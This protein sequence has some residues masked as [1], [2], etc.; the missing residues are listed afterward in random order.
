MSTDTPEPVRKPRRSRRLT[1]LRVLFGA[2]ALGL[3]ILLAAW[4]TVCRN[5]ACPS[6]EGLADY[7]P[8]QASKVYAADGRLITDLGLERRTV[9]PLKEISPAVIE[10]FLA[11][12]DKRFYDHHGIDWIRV[13]G[14]IKGILLGGRVTGASTITM[15]LAGNLFPEDISRRDRSVQRKLRE[16]KVALDIERRYPKDKILE[17]YLNQIDLGNRAYGVEAA[18]QR[19]FG[20]SAREL[21]IAE[22]ATLA[23]IPKAPTTYNPRRSP[24][25]SI[26]RRNLVIGLMRDEGLLARDEAER[27]RAFPLLLS[28][29]SDFTGVADYFVEYVRQQMQARFG[30]QLYR[31]GLRIYTSLDL[32]MQLAG[33]RALE[34]QLS[35]IEAGGPRYGKFPHKTYAQYLETRDDNTE[36]PSQSPYL[37]GLLVTLDAKTGYIRAMVGGRDFEDSKFNRVTQSRRQPG[38]TYKPFVFAAGLEAG[39]PLSELVMDDTLVMEVPGQDIWMPQN[40]DGKFEGRM[41]L[42]RALYQSRNIPTIKLG[43]EVGVENVL[44]VSRRFGITTNVRPVPSVSIGSADV[45]PLEIIAAYTGFA[46][47]GQR[48]VPQAI[49]RVEDRQGNILWQ[50]STR[51]IQV[52]EPAVAWLL[53]DVMR[54]VVRRGTAAGTVGSQINFPAAGKT[55]TTNDYFDVWYVGF[56]PDLVTGIWIGFD[57]PQK[58]MPN[59]QGGR[60]AAPAWTAMMKEIYERRPAPGGWARP[61]DL[62]AAEIDSTT[63]YLATPFCPKN[64][65][66]VES[67]APGTAPVTYCPVHSQLLGIPGLSPGPAPSSP[68][69][70]QPLT[71]TV[72]PTAPAPGQPQPAPGAMGGQG[73]PR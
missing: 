13:A 57:Q 56:T 47:G 59:A 33:E 42:R 24:A 25:R 3:A 52:L 2:V 54:D 17:L 62:Q 20:K 34:G 40:Y 37:Q 50:P 26:Q 8:A 58:I 39:H 5:N 29:R 41:T 31:D 60:L 36:P 55:G 61:E 4:A 48:A 23:A 43:L 65:R 9:V 67:F 22:A 30:D 68:G 19:Y 51:R 44:D 32:D 73:P 70:S 16:A 49:L 53:T 21:N 1:I 15:Q 6:L 7:D 72:V 46:N 12:E 28:S 71:G 14:A 69:E 38:S 18:S 11:T 10:A 63:G 64:L 45:V 35:A 66:Y 27:W